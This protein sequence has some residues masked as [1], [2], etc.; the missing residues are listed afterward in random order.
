MGKRHA[1]LVPRANEIDLRPRLFRHE[2]CESLK[3]ISLVVLTVT[4]VEA[5]SGHIER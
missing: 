5:T 4:R 1:E 3:G 2:Q